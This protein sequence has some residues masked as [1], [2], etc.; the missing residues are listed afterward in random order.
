ML[1][2]D[3]TARAA[4]HKH[5]KFSYE[6]R[7]YFQFR[8]L[9]LILRLEITSGFERRSVEFFLFFS[10]LLLSQSV[11]GETEPER[12]QEQVFVQ[13]NTVSI[14]IAAKNLLVCHVPTLSQFKSQLKTFL[15]AMYQHCLNS[16]RS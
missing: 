14:Q 10:L 6:R 11:L 13:T 12:E 8:L 7:V 1:S 15:F 4:K 2:F 5:R 3:V 16:N 9:R